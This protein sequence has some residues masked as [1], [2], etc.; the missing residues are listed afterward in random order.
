MLFEFS[1]I[2]VIEMASVLEEVVTLHKNLKSEWTS[3]PPNLEACGKLLDSLK[4]P[5]LLFFLS[6][7]LN[8]FTF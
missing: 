2:I 8:N 6:V 1:D 3:K 5:F 4:V 7:N